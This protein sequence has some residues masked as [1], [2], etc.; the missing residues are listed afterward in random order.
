M[1]SI[2]TIIYNEAVHR[3]NDT[4]GAPVT[5]TYSW[6]SDG[7]APSYSETT[8]LAMP[9]E[10][11]AEFRETFDLIESYT[12]LTFVEAASGGDMRIGMADLPSGVGAWA[13]YPNQGAVSGDV[14]FNSDYASDFE[15]MAAWRFEVTLHEVGH[16]LG[17]KHPFER[18]YSN[19]EALPTWFDSTTVTVMSYS[20]NRTAKDYRALDIEALQRLYGNDGDPHYALFAEEAGSTIVVGSQDTAYGGPGNDVISVDETLTHGYVG[21]PRGAGEPPP[22]FGDPPSGFPVPGEIILRDAGPVVAWIDA[23][24]NIEMSHPMLLA[25]EPFPFA[26]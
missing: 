16:A 13:Y 18:P 22:L 1:T 20:G 11:R 17:L 9:L 4:L 26:A 19:S 5:V 24:G 2:G 8:V 25:V 15:T 6:V 7:D 21:F 10:Y 12:G 14:W 23:N 3:W